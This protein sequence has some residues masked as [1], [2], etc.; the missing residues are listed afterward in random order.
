MKGTANYKPLDKLPDVIRVNYEE[1]DGY[2][3]FSS[4]DIGLNI[5]DKDMYSAFQL[6][7][8]CLI[9]LIKKDYKID[10]TVNL[11]TDPNPDFGNYFIDFKIEAVK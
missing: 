8:S 7:E 5:S 9:F 4:N 1:I 3:V 10:V 6:I 2:H 11:I